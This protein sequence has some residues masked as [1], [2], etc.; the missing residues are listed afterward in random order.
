MASRSRQRA[1]A[2]I[3]ELTKDTG[4]TA[5]F[6]ELDLAN[7][8]SVKRA[9]AEYMSKESTLNTLFNNGQVLYQRIPIAA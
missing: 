7:L 6:L 1:E 3:A 9:A 2:V 4:N 8:A 5:I